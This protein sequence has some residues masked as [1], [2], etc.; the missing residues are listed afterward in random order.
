MT[1]FEKHWC[2]IEEEAKH[3]RLH[4][5]IKI[6]REGGECGLGKSCADCERESLEWLA[7]EYKEPEVDWTKVAVDT[8]ILVS[9][10]GEKWYNR[11][12]AKCKSGSVYVWGYRA[13]SWSIDDVD[14]VILW[15]Y[16]KLA[17]EVEK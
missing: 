3:R 12:F 11:Y 6:V 17:E 8:P 10:G 15:P 7:E 2:A 9:E 16:A 1:N 5:A 4:C 13:T 14:N